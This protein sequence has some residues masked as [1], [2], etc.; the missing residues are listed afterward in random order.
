MA[1]ME[2]QVRL[3]RLVQPAEMEHLVRQVQPDQLGQVLI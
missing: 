2:Y 1:P 3:D